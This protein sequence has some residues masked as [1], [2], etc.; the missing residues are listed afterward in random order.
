MPLTIEQEGFNRIA[1]RLRK[2]GNLH[3][4][5]EKKFEDDLIQVFAFKKRNRLHPLLG[6][7]LIFI[8]HDGDKRRARILSEIAGAPINYSLNDPSII[9]QEL[10]ERLQAEFH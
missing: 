7:E 6:P 1:K 2:A 3:S 9:V 4:G 8:K 10:Y 5:S